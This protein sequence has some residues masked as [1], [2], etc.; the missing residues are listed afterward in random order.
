MQTDPSASTSD[1]EKKKKW[2]IWFV[3]TDVIIISAFALWFIFEHTSQPSM[4]QTDFNK[5]CKERAMKMSD[6]A[7]SDVDIQFVRSSASTSNTFG[8]TIRL[9]IYGAGGFPTKK[10]VR[11]NYQRG[12]FLV[13]W[14]K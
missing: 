1:N 2:L 13:E 10:Y 3:V 4:S 14:A 11:C 7:N 9:M 8:A 6:A 5:M 12:K